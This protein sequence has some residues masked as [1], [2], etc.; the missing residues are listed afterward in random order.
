MYLVVYNCL[1]WS[2]LDRQTFTRTLLA[3]YQD[4]KRDLPWRDIRDPY[5]IWLS[6]IILQQTRVEQGMPYYL[7]FCHNFPTVLDLAAASEQK[8]LRLWQG[9]G[10]YSRARNLLRCAR[11]IA[12][13]YQ[14]IF[15]ESYEELVALPGIGDYTA[16]AIASFAFK[17]PTPVVDGNVF[18]VLSRIFAI[19]DDIGL[20]RSRKVFKEC[21]S[22]L[23]A[24]SPPDR[25]NQAIME[26]G[27]LH[28]TPA[29]PKCHQCPFNHFCRAFQLGIQH[30]YPVKSK[31]K[32]VRKRLF[33]YFVVKS[34]SQVLMRKRNEADI[35]QGLYDFLLVESDCEHD[36]MELLAGHL[37]QGSWMDGIQVGEPTLPYRHRLSH[38]LIQAHFVLIEPKDNKTFTDWKKAFKLEAYKTAEIQDLPKPILIDNYLKADIF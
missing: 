34:G 19:Q 16:S 10:Y 24:G 25:Y 14:G 13:S 29:R 30:R 36:A 1:T 26:F 9:L 32:E 5:K 12:D 21:S 38:Q 20:Q 2:I 15:P 27:A 17:K 18:R 3:W 31:K 33:Y 22:K 7:A 28:C 11:M 35:W 37:P 8:V 4:N 6:E 23:M